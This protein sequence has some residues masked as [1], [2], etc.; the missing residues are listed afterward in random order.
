MSGI[1]NQTANG[2]GDSRDTKQVQT[3]AETPGWSAATIATKFKEMVKSQFAP[4]D[5][6]A[7]REILRRDGVTEEVLFAIDRSSGKPVPSGQGYARSRLELA[8]MMRPLKS[9][10]H[11]YC[12]P[13][14]P[15]S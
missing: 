14:R 12:C 3:G 8:E 15:A 2:S 1:H 11:Y 5:L 6:D 4:P 13:V 10:E 7:A 9:G